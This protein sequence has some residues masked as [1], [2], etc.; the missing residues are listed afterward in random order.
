MSADFNLKRYDVITIKNPRGKIWIKKNA[1]FS[2]D[3]SFRPCYHFYSSVPH[4]TNLNGYTSIISSVIPCRCNRRILSQP[5]RFSV[6]RYPVRCASQKP[7]SRPLLMHP[8]QPPGILCNSL[9]DGT[10]FVTVFDR[11]ERD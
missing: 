10:L 5:C 1:F 3:E 8:S 2:E 11:I 6:T 9:T 4:S 7:C